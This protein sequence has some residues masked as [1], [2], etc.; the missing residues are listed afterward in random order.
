MTDAEYA[1]RAEAPYG[2]LSPETVEFLQAPLQK[3]LDR[4]DE[5]VFIRWEEVEETLF[6]I[7]RYARIP[8][9]TRRP[10]LLILAES[11]MGKS[12]MYEEFCLREGVDADTGIGRSGTHEMFCMSL[13]GLNNADEFLLRVF[14]TIGE[15]SP[16]SRE[17]R[18][19]GP[20]DLAAA[21]LKRLDLKL[22]VLDECQQLAEIAANEAAK[23]CS[24]IRHLSN[25][26]KR[27]I[28]M[29]GSED[30]LL[31]VQ[32]SKH[33][34]TRI[35][36]QYVPR[37]ESIEELRAFVDALL[38]YIPLNSPS[39]ITDDKSLQKLIEW[40]D[41]VTEYIV[42]SIRKAARRALRNGEQCITFR[43]LE[44]SRHRVKKRGTSGAER[45]DTG[46]TDD[47]K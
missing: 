47:S 19:N 28:V 43:R 2:H 15:P 13:A 12:T 22:L 32:K 39:P 3:I 6:E 34:M 20:L 26:C 4:V 38:S 16:I 5:D 27:P 18:K 44:A 7:Q 1:I 41:G 21:A 37:W 9:G 14:R 35:D 25:A 31:P 23:I 42:K 8:K 45:R 11:G 10:V 33:L 46:K 30:T 29:M 40:T 36:Q 17:A 24:Y